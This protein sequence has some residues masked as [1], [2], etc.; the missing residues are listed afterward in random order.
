[1][2]IA[3]YG[4]KP[5]DKLWFEPLSQEYG[6]NIHF[7]EAGI[8]EDT[9]VLA[10]GCMAVCV[11]VNDYITENIAHKLSDM[12]IKLI[13][14]RCAGFNNV[15]LKAVKEYGIKVL[16]LTTWLHHNIYIEQ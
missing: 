8:S 16:C 14:L 12:G 5:Y 11:F 3:F 4:T 10:E 6:Y 15:D 1:M 9:L 2:D 13:L 7:I